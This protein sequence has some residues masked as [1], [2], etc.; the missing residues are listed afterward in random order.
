MST[1]REPGR[2]RNKDPFPLIACPG[3]AISFIVANILVD[4]LLDDQSP[5]HSRL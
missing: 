2:V 5:L 3:D 4:A 1:D